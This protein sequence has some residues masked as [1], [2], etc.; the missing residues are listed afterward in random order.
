MT[1]KNPFR[2][3][4]VGLAVSS[5]V[6]VQALAAGSAGAVTTTKAE[7][8]NGAL[9]VVGTSAPGIFVIAE[10][11]T[12]SA[13]VRA[14]QQGRFDLQSI[15]FTAPDCKVTI[16]DGRT[17]NATASL[18]GCTPS[19]TPVP[20][21]PAPP[22]GSCVIT[23]QAQVNLT[24]GTRSVVNFASTGCDTTTGSGATPT[25]V[26]W[27]VVAGVIPTGMTGPNFQGTTNANLIGTPSVRATYRF[28][29]QATDQ[30]GATD[31]QTFTINVI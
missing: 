22:T 1:T 4:A 26:R 28:T 20:P 7:L 8:R 25:P 9:R 24:A 15:H 29:L 17:A 12:S 14:D 19:V 5:C 3:T 11:T 2:A 23:P 30:I 21:N 6:A 31:Q 18:A 27:S 13:G 16:R 10:S